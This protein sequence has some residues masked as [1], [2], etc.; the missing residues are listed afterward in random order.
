MTP[1]V[2]KFL[3]TT[4]ESINFSMIGPDF[5]CLVS[6]GL[7][8]CCIQRNSQVHAKAKK[9]KTSYKAENITC[10]RAL[11]HLPDAATT[12]VYS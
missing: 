10:L 6:P 11:L 4:A 12:A 9:N 1:K 5:M 2:D 8:P 3:R 7:T